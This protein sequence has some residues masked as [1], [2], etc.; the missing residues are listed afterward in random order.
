MGRVIFL[1]FDTQDSSPKKWNS[2]SLQHYQ[3]VIN[4]GEFQ[5]HKGDAGDS[6]HFLI[7]F[8]TKSISLFATSHLTQPTTTYQKSEELEK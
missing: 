5:R 7:N 1:P 2:S 4:Q 8:S 3:T 6:S